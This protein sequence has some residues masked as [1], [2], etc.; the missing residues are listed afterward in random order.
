[1]TIA[2]RTPEGFPSQCPLCGQPAEIDF[3]D[4]ADD[5]PCPHCGYLIWLSAQ[6][7]EFLCRH[8]AAL[9]NVPLESVSLNTPLLALAG[10]SLESVE[11]IMEFEEAF[12]IHIPDEVAESI[13][14]VSDLIRYLTAR[15]WN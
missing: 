8:K 5:A 6:V 13:R 15:R 9:L 3:S 4:P 12:Q 7:I 14:T 1:M 10:D 11:L 2:S